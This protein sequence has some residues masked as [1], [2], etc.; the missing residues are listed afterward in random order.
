MNNAVNLIKN[1]LSDEKVIP[2][3]P[4]LTKPD[5][6]GLFLTVRQIT[7]RFKKVTR[8]DNPIGKIDSN[9]AYSIFPDIMHQ[10]DQDK[11]NLRR[12][13]KGEE[14]ICTIELEDSDQTEAF[15]E[16]F[17]GAIEISQTIFMTNDNIAKILT[18]A[19]KVARIKSIAPSTRKELKYIENE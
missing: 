16:A 5:F 14:C 13:I 19:A 10:A 6:Q 3:K 7:D 8:K 18:K 12:A 11:T 15:R 1:P 4:K 17:P 9:P 2:T